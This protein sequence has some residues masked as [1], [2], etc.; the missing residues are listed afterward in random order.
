MAG[1][2]S[3]PARRVP[4]IGRYDVAVIGGG[5]AG[6]AAAVAAA[7]GRARVLLVEQTGC[8]G[9]MGT[10]GQVPAFCPYSRGGKPLI[11]GIGLEVL[12]RLRAAGG[13]GRDHSD[14]GWIPI[15]AEILKQVYDAMVGR[16]R[17][18]LRLFT[19]FSDTVRRGR[20]LKAVVFE[21]KAGRQAAVADVFVDATGDGDVAARAGVAFDLGDAHGRMQAASLCFALAGVD[22]SRYWTYVNRVGGGRI[23]EWLREQESRGR[24]KRIPRTEYRGVHGQEIAPGVLGFNF[25]HLYEVNGTRPEDLARVMVDGREMIRS[26]VAFA[27]KRM[28]GMR[29]A[30]LVSTAA[31]PG[32]RET[33]RIRGRARLTL[34]D[35]LAGRH[36]ADE[37][38]EYDYT[39]DVHNARRSAALFKKFVRD[40]DRRALPPGR[41]YG[42]PY[43]CL[44]PAEVDNLLVAGRALSAD[45]EAHGS[46]RVMPACFATG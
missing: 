25:G 3:E 26:F 46:V 23:M 45:R 33:R 19:F 8:L 7:R 9:G 30:S 38:A 6:V 27:R 10:A 44:L 35:Y 42:I 37:I 29:G 40:F 43:R 1:Y 22:V 41:S 24:L 34:D 15:N 11:R 28:P 12:E 14:Y 31:L 17:I 16:E 4:V 39:V 2:V 21:S 32:I 20:R 13:V 36:F 5:P 18:D